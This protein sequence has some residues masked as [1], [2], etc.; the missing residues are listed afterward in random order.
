MAGVTLWWTV[1]GVSESAAMSPTG[2]G[3]WEGEIPAQLPDT[4][5]SYW[6][7]ATD[8]LN[9]TREPEYTDDTFRVYLPAPTDLVAPSGRLVATEVTLS[10]SPPDSRNAVLGY[11]IVSGESSWDVTETT[12]TVPVTGGEQGFLVRALYEAGPGDFSNEALVDAVV[13]AVH[14][15]EPAVAYA[16]DTLRVRLEGDYLLLVDGA[17]AVDLGADV[18]VAGVDVRSVDEAWLDLV[19]G[20]D[21]A[22]GLR[23]LTVESGDTTL[24]AEG[25]FTVLPASDRPRLTE[26]KPDT[27]RQG[28]SGDLSLT[29]TGSF[30]ELPTVDLGEG[31]V[32][33]AVSVDG[34]QL[35]VHY[36]VTAQAPLGAHA[37]TVDDGVRILSGVDLE[38]KDAYAPPADTCGVPVPPTFALVAAGVFL[39]RRR[40]A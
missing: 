4:Q 5:V 25:A 9:E 37:V 16:G 34:D 14:A 24:R 32:A 12:A 26:V 6:V 30:S 10:W 31:L 13:P 22:P 36:V 40:R 3:V 35:V 28:D 29:F 19:V 7:A 2:D 33:S 27:V 11:E 21:A 39:V 8:G 20:E 1:D 17:V 18:T 38:V 15:L 23:T